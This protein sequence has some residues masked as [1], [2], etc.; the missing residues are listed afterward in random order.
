MPSTP[1]QDEIVP[2]LI[3]QWDVLDGLL[4]EIPEADWRAASILPGWRVQDIVSHIVGTELMLLGEQPPA[5]VSDPREHEHVHNDIAAINEQWVE[6]LHDETPERMRDRFRAVMSQRATTLR[7]LSS[8]QWDQ[9]SFGP[10]G[11]TTFGG[12]M[13]IRLFDCWMHELDLRDSTGLAGD[14]GGPRGVISLDVI[15]AGLPYA[16]GRKARAPR[17]STITFT[18]TGPVE[19]AIHIEVGE[20]ARLV[21]AHDG[22]PT[23]AITLPF[24]LLARLAAGRVRAVDHRGEITVE[25]DAGLATAIL[26]NLAF[27]M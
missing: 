15:A 21:P 8:E 27:V 7:E 2:A 4:R 25:G 17:G 24:G 20:K 18:T 14:E 22:P 23:V 16:V 26:D 10:T 19:R 13:R 5:P 11:P 6:H 9:A 1:A 12:F 3:E